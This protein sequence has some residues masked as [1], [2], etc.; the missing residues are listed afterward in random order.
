MKTK[1]IL[2][3]VVLGL[4]VFSFVPTVLGSGV[5]KRS[6][7]DDWFIQVDGQSSMNDHIGWWASEDLIIFPHS[8]SD[9]SFVP[10]TACDEYHGYIHEREMTDGRHLITVHIRV[11]GAPVMV[12]TF[13]PDNYVTLFEGK[14]N[15]LFQLKFIIDIEIWPTFLLFLD[16]D[17][18]DNKTGYV[19]L[20]LYLPLAIDSLWGMDMGLEFVSVHFVG[21]GKGE[22]VN[23]WNG[24]ERG[25]TAKLKVATYGF[26]ENGYNF[27]NVWAPVWPLDY[28]KLY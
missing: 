20:P 19:I 28:I 27:I 16:D 5:I 23:D 15:Y 14:M 13:D 22:M 7:E 9:W 12:E 1:K 6:L 18:F 17:G 10:I 25:D 3:G 26:A 2:L 11:K 21:T 8:D 4:L 24:L